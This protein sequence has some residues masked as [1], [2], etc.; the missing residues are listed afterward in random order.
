MVQTDR[1]VATDV[2]PARTPQ[3]PG[4]RQEAAE[5][6]FDRQA[7]A[8]ADAESTGIWYIRNILGEAGV[9]VSAR[10]CTC[11]MGRNRL[12]RVDTAMSE[13]TGGH[14]V[15]EGAVARLLEHSPEKSP[16]EG[17][18]IAARAQSI[19]SAEPPSRRAAE[20]PSRRAAEPPSRRAAEPPSRRAAEP[21]SRR[22]AEPPSDESVRRMASAPAS[23]LPA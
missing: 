12:R 15:D 3:W 9:R 2:E 18:T 8:C 20:P 16:P 1:F 14:G 19:M 11:V 13:L 4:A 22:A 6:E 10:V 17:L 5:G 23:F 21:P 7:D